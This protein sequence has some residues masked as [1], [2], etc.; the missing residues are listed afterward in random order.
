MLAPLKMRAGANKSAAIAA[1]MQK[2]PQLVEAAATRALETAIQHHNRSVTQLRRA[3][4]M[5]GRLAASRGGLA[6]P[7]PGASS[8][9]PPPKVPHLQPGSVAASQQTLS[10]DSLQAVTPPSFDPLEPLPWIE[11]LA[12][13][14][15][16]PKEPGKAI[17]PF[18]SRP[19]D[20]MIRT[21]GLIIRLYPRP[22]DS[23]IDRATIHLQVES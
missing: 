19:R 9:L 18:A 22:S 16:L 21:C 4:K 13:A 17:P 10:S 14:G 15:W 23:L 11:L 2:Y 7:A 6:A 1:L 5:M 12:I 8:G 20:E 3:A